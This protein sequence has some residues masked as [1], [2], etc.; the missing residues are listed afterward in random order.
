MK[1][2]R[3]SFDITDIPSL[4]AIPKDHTTFE[5]DYEEEGSKENGPAV[6]SPLKGDEVAGEQEYSL[7]DALQSVSRSSTPPLFGKNNTPKNQYDYSTSLKSEPKVGY[8]TL[9]LC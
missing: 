8:G 5:R 7:S 2:L 6:Y 3:D 4:S 9:G 1:S